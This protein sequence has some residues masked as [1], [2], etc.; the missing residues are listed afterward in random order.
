MARTA[1]SKRKSNKTQWTLNVCRHEAIVNG[2]LV[3]VI[4]NEETQLADI[5]LYPTAQNGFYDAYSK[6]EVP[7]LDKALAL[8][9]SMAHHLPSQG[10]EWTEEGD[11]YRSV[12]GGR[13]VVAVFNHRV[14]AVNIT[15]YTRPDGGISAG[16]ARAQIGSVES[17]LSL[18]ASMAVAMSA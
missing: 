18:T 8:A 3:H 9:E 1:K 5:T 12:I 6:M 14:Q 4:F 2:R 15:I 13:M 11:S 16:T 7:T 17:G 10:V